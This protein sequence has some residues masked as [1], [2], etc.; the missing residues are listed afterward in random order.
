MTTEPKYPFVKFRTI[1][2]L[3][4]HANPNG[5]DTPEVWYLRVAGVHNNPQKVSD[6]IKSKRHKLLGHGN[7]VGQKYNDLRNY[8]DSTLGVGVDSRLLDD[9]APKALAEKVA[10]EVKS[11]KA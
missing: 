5:V 10:N 6:Y 1:K 9:D 11:R 3:T 8:I 7:L 4:S 2:K